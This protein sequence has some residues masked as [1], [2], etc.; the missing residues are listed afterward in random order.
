MWDKHD[1]H[2][3]LTTNNETYLRKDSAR[4]WQL[5]HSS[6]LNQATLNVSLSAD[7]VRC[8]HGN[9]DFQ[10]VVRRVGHSDLV[11]RNYYPRP[12]T[13]PLVETT[14]HPTSAIFYSVSFGLIIDECKERKT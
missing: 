9:S 6:Y 11:G 5:T 7:L 3:A 1:L 13:Q 8:C 4:H 2:N 10:G 12:R 14:T